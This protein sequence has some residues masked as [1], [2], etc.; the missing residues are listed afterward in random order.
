MFTGPTLSGQADYLNTNLSTTLVQ[1]VH[2]TF[3]FEKESSMPYYREK[4]YYCHCETT[5]WIGPYFGSRNTG[6]YSINLIVKEYKHT[7]VYKIKFDINA[8]TK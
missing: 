2:S 3:E 8:C 4:D 6:Q 1:L 7:E 5:T